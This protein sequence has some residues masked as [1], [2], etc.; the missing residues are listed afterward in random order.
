MSKAMST[1]GKVAI[2]LLVLIALGGLYM[3]SMGTVSYGPGGPSGFFP[4]ILPKPI[5]NI[6][7]VSYNVQGNLVSGYKLPVTFIVSNSGNGD[8]TGVRATITVYDKNGAVFGNQDTSLG[9]ISPG[10]S[11]SGTATFSLSRLDMLGGA[12]YT[13]RIHVSSNEGAYVDY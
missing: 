5:L 10:G 7:S 3:F 9:T 12:S 6:G 2:V 1:G 13:A 11:A 4:K 8:A